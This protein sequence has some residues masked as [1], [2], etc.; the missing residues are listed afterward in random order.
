MRG[1]IALW[2]IVCGLSLTFAGQ[3]RADGVAYESDPESPFER[4]PQDE[5]IAAI[6]HRDG[7][8]KLIIAI[9]ID[10]EQD[11]KAVWIFPV[12][13]TP[14]RVWL[15]VLDTFPEFS[16]KN[17]RGQARM[18]IERVT[19]VMAVTQIYPVILP[20]F[21]IA[22][23]G[24]SSGFEPVSVHQAVDRYGVHAEAVSADSLEALSAHLAANG[25]TIAGEDL[26]TFEP[27]VS[28]EYVLV[29]AWIASR[30]ELLREFPEVR[31]GWWHSSQRWPCLYV[32]F[33]TE[34]A[35]YP[36]RP[37]SAYGRKW[38]WISVYVVGFVTLDVDDPEWAEEH[39]GVAYCRQDGFGPNAPEQ[40]TEGFTE[41]P[42][43]YTVVYDRSLTADQL[44]SDL[45]FRPHREVPPAGGRGEAG[46]GAFPPGLRSDLCA[47]GICGEGGAAR[48]ARL[49]CG[50]AAV[51]CV[52]AIGRRETEP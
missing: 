17:L 3:A 21:F 37:T 49:T 10:L 2:A 15:D 26:R 46:P 11:E 34:R 39:F 14:D 38:I 43:R 51:A 8:E 13:G 23:A 40:F 45:W 44:T 4:S 42:V 30:E 52:A 7:V 12:P 41:S 29:L 48:A 24:G 5:Q 25:A 50:A 19:A 20:L 32:E 18:A 9:N 47:P 16:G 35:F 22:T 33:P 27:Y 28:D 6:A 31:E 36:L 1:R